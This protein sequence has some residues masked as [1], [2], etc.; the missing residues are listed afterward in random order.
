MNK[1]K[2][3]LFHT[4]SGKF[5]MSKEQISELK[6]EIELNKNLRQSI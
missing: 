3:S 5:E 6:K 2:R 4:I 1:K